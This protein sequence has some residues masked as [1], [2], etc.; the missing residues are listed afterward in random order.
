MKK[1]FLIA[2]LF[3]LFGCG[4]QEVEIGEEATEAEKVAE[5][6]LIIAGEGGDSGSMFIKSANTYRQKNGGEIYE[7]HSG[8]E[9]ISA[10]K[11]F[12]SRNG[13]IKH[14]EYF[15]HGN[16]VGLYVNQAPNVN[17]G[18]YANDVDQN[19]NYIAASIYELND[20]IF[21]RYGW[22]RFN[23]CNVASGYPENETL[24][25]RVA[26]YF[27]VDTVAPMGPTE[28]SSEEGI[29][30]PIPNSSYLDPNFDGEVYMVPTYSDQGFIVIKPQEKCD[31]GFSDV[32]KGQ[33]FE[34]GVREIE[35]RGLK[36]EL[37][38]G[39]Q[40]NFSEEKF[41]PIGKFLPYSNVTYS[42]AAEFCKLAVNGKEGA[43]GFQESL[44]DQ[45]I[46]NLQALKM[47]T[48][49]YG[50]EIKYTNPWYDAY[51]WWANN[52]NLLTKDFVTKKWYTRGEMAELT[53]N[54]MK[55]FA[56]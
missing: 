34:E 36:K 41:L 47:L 43:C 9:F 12:V 28:F 31:C 17:G 53:W 14:L 5:M 4:T 7:V 26:N 2:I 10:V 29:V 46:R 38:K 51:V 49:A 22:I 11:D 50:V 30:N 8:D 52:E 3:I 16:N 13:K 1:F 27:G 54:F 33:S 48:D 44:A 35:K 23:G 18:L 55:K 56:E 25:Q 37:E 6:P 45:K 32:Y 42:E 21:A 39:E 15:G 24:G 19:K 20:D 40:V